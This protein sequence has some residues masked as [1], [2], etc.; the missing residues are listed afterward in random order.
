MAREKNTDIMVARLLQAAGIE[1]TA[2]ISG[3]KEIDEALKTAS[4]RGTGHIGSPEFLAVVDGFVLVVEDK[5]DTD[6]QVALLDDGSLDMSLKA[7]TDYAVNGGVHYGKHIAANTPF[8]KVFAIGVSGDEKHHVIQPAFC[9]GDTVQVLEPVETFTNFNE[10]NIGAFYDEQVRG[11]KADK[12][13]ELEEIVKLA[14]ELHEDLRDYAQLGEA[15]KPIVVS[16][17][18]LALQ[19]PSFNLDQ[20][21]GDETRTDGQIVWTALESHL[22][23]IRVKPDVKRE[24][25][26]NQ[27][28]IIKDRTSLNKVRKDLGKTPLQYYGEFLKK[29]ILES[30]RANVKEDILG[31]FYSEFMSYSGGDGQSLGVVLTPTHICQLFCD[32]LE[33]KPTDTVFDPCTGTS[34]FLIA[35]MHRMLNAAENANQRTEIKEQQI[36]G[37]ELREDMFTVATTNMILRGDGRSNLECTDF[38][39]HVAEEIQREIAPS[40]GMMNPPYSQGKNNATS[41]LREISFVEHLI[42]SMSPGGRVA[43]IVPQSTMIGK[44]KEDQKTKQ[45]ILKH[46]TLKTVVTLNKNTFYQVGTN[47]CIAV[48][49]AHEPH[50][51]DKLVKF[52]NFEDDGWVVRK[53]VGLVETETAKD[54]LAKLLDCYRNKAEAPSRF[55]VETTVEASDEWLHSFYYFNDE[56]P[57]EA[58]FQKTIADYLTFEFDMITHGRGYLFEKEEVPC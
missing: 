20:L 5:R 45:R 33:V 1:A 28:T 19:D 49:I 48:F 26:L 55:M 9:D 41:Q 44:S 32:L 57:S 34:S 53:H 12:E 56:I 21:T 13:I 22:R 10:H 42:D 31:R 25:I 52:F 3:V 54:K 30:L 17:L 15:E 46:H 14:K 47:P 11:I 43:V 58:D 24:M 6:F 4:K 35:A 51:K 16:A 36:H 37:Y 50:P 8:K 2:E 23:R 40:V 29:N 27:F 18:L 7:V 38:F 39:D